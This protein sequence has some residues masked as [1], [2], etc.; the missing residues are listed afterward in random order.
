MQIPALVV[1]CLSLASFA[2]AQCTR[3][4]VPA[5]GFAVREL[6]DEQITYS[7]GAITMGRLLVPDVAPPSC[8]WPLVVYVHSLGSDRSQELP[9][10]REL[11]GAGFAVWAYAVRGQAE[12]RVL[13]RNGTSLYGPN[14]RYDLAEQIAW[15][16]T[17]HAAAVSATRVGITGESQGGIHGWMA[18]AQSGKP[19]TVRMRGTIQFPEI[20]AVAGADFVAEPMHHR[21]R[22]GTLFSANFVELVLA[23]EN[24][25][26][27]RIDPAFATEVKT[28]FAMQDPAGLAA[29]LR[30]EP[31][32]LVEPEL[33]NTTVPILYF[34]GYYDSLC[35]AG[36]LVDAVD[37]LPAA[38]PCRIVLSATGHSFPPRA[39]V[40][41]RTLRRT[42]VRRWFE[43]FLWDAP[44][45]VDTEARFVLGSIPLDPARYEDPDELLGYSH[46]DR[47]P[48]SDVKVE[49]LYTDDQGG[50]S[51]AEPS[52]GTPSR[53][54]HVVAPGFGPAEYTADPS[55]RTITG[56]LQSIPLSEAVFDAVPLVADVEF[57]GRPLVSLAVVPD[58]ADF[59]IVAM[60][61][62]RLPGATDFKM[63][64]EWGR[65]VLSAV[66]D[67]GIRV[68]FAL[69]PIS[70]RLPAGTV[71]RL[72]L[73][74]HWLA[75]SPHIAGFVTVPL[76]SDSTVS[77]EHG[78]GPAA[79]FVELPLREPRAVLRCARAVLPIV[80]PGATTLSVAGGVDR[81]G[82]PYVLAAS[83]SGQAPGTALPG[84]ILPLNIDALTLALS[85]PTPSA[86]GM[87]GMLDPAGD[88]AAVLDLSPLAVLPP[89]MLGLRLTFAAWVHRSLSDPTGVATNP[90]D[91]V[92]R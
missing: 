36:P 73:R 66:P 74:N 38:T 69:S 62:A 35:G 45:G 46:E 52:S 71:V 57:I 90:V 5:G 19:L 83:M 53:I 61:S 20:T 44:N 65:G 58:A 42:L 8:G 92:V 85:V 48:P 54:A 80:T 64:S 43:R 78:A 51:E 18:A 16:R 60:V 84:G 25:F 14:E 24:S 47:F 79:T 28:R 86:S 77:V 32:R 40:Y 67:V 50:L 49:R 76:F 12:A 15:V 75:E 55:R 82:M 88:A 17:T 13:S 4:P 34:H 68:E 70:A 21:L 6:P 39:N 72:T 89:A 81:G 7:D 31:G 9:W 63:L 37:L 10:Q 1:V 23:A 26:G 3:P 41:D 29:L 91:L 22:G 56:I 59:T 2:R 11:A 27:F 33:A 87:W 30:A